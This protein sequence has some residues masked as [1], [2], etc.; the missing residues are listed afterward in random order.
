MRRVELAGSL[1]RRRETIKDLD[2]VAESDQPEEVMRAFIEGPGVERVVNHGATKSS[3]VLA[4]GIPADL[5]VVSR[6]QFP[7]ALNY[8]TGSK[9]HNTRLRGRAKKMGLKLNEY[10]LFAEGSEKAMDCRDEAAIYERLGLAYIEPELREDMGEIEASEA[11]E[12][13]PLIASS[14]LRGLLHCHSTYSDGRSTL[15]EM[16]QAA[17]AAGYEYFGICDHS[18][19]AAYAGGLKSQDV[20]RQHEEIERINERMKNFRVLKGIESDILGDGSLDYPDEFLE[21]FDFVVISV[22]SRFQLSRAEM[23]RRICKALAHPAATILGHPTGR[24]LLRRDPYE[25]DLEEV[26]AVAAEHNVAVEINANPHRLDLDWRTLRSAKKAGCIF[27]I[28]PDAHHTDGIADVEF[29]IGI[30][31]KGWLEASDVINT[32]GLEQF[33]SWLQ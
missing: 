1:R 24:L 17:R 30:A 13:P 3:V 23:T 12:L 33:E 15:A 5:R 32:F 4:G 28:N 20:L 16:S 6:D 14:D 27:S 2:L 31:R 21:R 8:F 11:G 22:H 26:F 19:S 7:A 18:Q 25:V 9:E 29:G 10:G